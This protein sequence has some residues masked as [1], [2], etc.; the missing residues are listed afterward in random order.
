M[1]E[2]ISMGAAGGRERR[3]YVGPDARV[4]DGKTLERGREARVGALED[5]PRQHGNVHAGVALRSKGSAHRPT[6]R[7]RRRSQRIDALWGA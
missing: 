5:A 3:G 6:A 2:N 1:R 4:P 7:R